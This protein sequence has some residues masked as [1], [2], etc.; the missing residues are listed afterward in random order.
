MLTNKLFFCIY[1]L[2][3]VGKNITDLWLIGSWCLISGDGRIIRIINCDDKDLSERV[4][5]NLKTSQPFE[6][7]LVD[8]GQVVKIKSANQLY[9][10]SPFHSKRRSIWCSISVSFRF[11][12]D[13][14]QV[15]SFSQLR[16]IFPQEDTFLISEGPPRLAAVGG[17]GG[18]GQAWNSSDLRDPEE[19]SDYGQRPAKTSLYRW[20]KYQSPN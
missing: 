3:Q 14:H 11:C 8:L 1:T 16:N 20:L 2:L 19:D 5:L 10:R 4:L 6:E 7:V 18:E 12:R 15:R 13:G 9:T 17:G